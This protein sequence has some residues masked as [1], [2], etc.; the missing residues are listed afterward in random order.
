MHTVGDPTEVECVTTV[1]TENDAPA[2]ITTTLYDLIATIQ[3]VVGPDDD[4]LVVATAWH[5]LY[6]GRVTWHDD[7]VARVN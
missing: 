5:V 2:T 1:G 4:A 6:A 7:V 3:A